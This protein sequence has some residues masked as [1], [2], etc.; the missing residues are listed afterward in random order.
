MERGG[1]RAVQ[2]HEMSPLTWEVLTFHLS[3]R[4]SGTE[5]RGGGKQGIRMN[6]DMTSCI[7]LSHNVIVALSR[8]SLSQNKRIM[9]G[10]GLVTMCMSTKSKKVFM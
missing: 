5:R 4:E 1:E 9:K 8:W 7:S 6:P 2:D 3:G 10:L